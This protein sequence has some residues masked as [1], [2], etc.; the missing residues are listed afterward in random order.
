MNRLVILLFCISLFS[1]DSEKGWDCIKTVGTIVTEEREVTPFSQIVVEDD[2]FLTIEEGEQYSVTVTTGENLINDITVEVEAGI[3]KLNN[4]AKCN[5]N[6]AY[7]VSFVHVVTPTLTSIRSSSVNE[8]RSVGTLS[9]KELLLISNT[10]AGVEDA[11]K[12]GDFILD[13]ATELFRI[14]ANG[15]SEFFISGTTN[16]LRVSFLDE[17]PKLSAGNLIADKVSFT[18]RSANTITVFP[19]NEIIGTILGAGDVIV[20]NKPSVVMVE[21]PSIGQLIFE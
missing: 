2:L 7:D 10:D 19:V 16:Q 14:N 1:C 11:G 17:I 18:T 8:V 4:T 13:V 5:F 21:T 6:R 9:Y 3:L 20:K 12:S 15:Q